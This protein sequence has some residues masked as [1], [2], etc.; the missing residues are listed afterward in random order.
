MQRRDI[1]AAD[2]PAPA[3]QYTQAVEVTGAT[4]TLYVSGQVGVAADGSIPDDAMAQSTLAWRNLQAQLRAAGMM[5]DNLVKTT[6]IVP[7]RAD[8]A[9]VRAGR[10][11]VL[12]DHRPASTLIVGGL[13][14]PAWKV[15]VEAIAVA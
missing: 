6:T 9:A 10:A 15:E 1:N 8:L 7:D 12:G 14:N 3:G 13:S 2:G 11:A 4:R 5:L